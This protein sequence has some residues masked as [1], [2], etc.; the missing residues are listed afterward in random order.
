MAEQ[1]EDSDSKRFDATP[2]K[3]ED[4]RKKGEVPHSQDLTTTAA[5]TGFL[6]AALVAGQS[7]LLEIG[8]TLSAFM[9]QST[10]PDLRLGFGTASQTILYRDLVGLFAPW[11]ALPA[12]GALVSI[13]GQRAF[14]VAGEKVK[15]KLSRI[16]PLS[17]AKQKFGANGLFEFA[18][19]TTKLLVFAVVLGLFIYR[20]LPVILAVLYQ[21]AEVAILAIFGLLFDFLASVVIVAAAIGGFDFVWQQAEHARRH[22]MSQK[23]IKDESKE[24]DGD[25]HLKQN[26]RQ[27]GIEIATNRMLADVPNADVVI[28]NPSHYAV[29]LTWDR[30]SGRA[31]VCVAKGLDAIAARIRETAAAAGVPIHRDPPTARALYAA[32]DI[33][34]EIGREDFEAV[35]A[36]IRFAD[37]VRQKVRSGPRS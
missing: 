29:A 18:K 12:L 1:D 21:P 33:G 30:G 31:P 32:L 15:P 26:R 36:A 27:K 11:F 13:V 4:A 14:V 20:R 17:T 5:Y 22:R 34:A 19:S 37:A 2:K 10:D 25:P 8:A 23:E 24:S 28:V 35:A 6:C 9:A 16:S 7:N 3:L